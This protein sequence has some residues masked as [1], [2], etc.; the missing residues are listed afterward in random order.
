M[1]L[2][3]SFFFYIVIFRLTLIDHQCWQLGTLKCFLVLIP[4]FLFPLV[5]IYIL[6]LEL[7]KS[8]S[9]KKNILRLI[10]YKVML[11]NT[12]EVVRDKF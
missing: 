11:L 12:N 9:N 1:G 10:V 5:E 3:I 4:I 6:L 7:S 2:S 8:D